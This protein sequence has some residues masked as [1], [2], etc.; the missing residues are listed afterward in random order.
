MT[1]HKW[2]V[3]AL[4]NADLLTAPV[5]TSYGGKASENLLIVVLGKT[6][7]SSG[8]E[9][10]AGRASRQSAKLSEC[11]ASVALPV[12][13]SGQHCSPVYARVDDKRNGE[14][15]PTLA[16]CC[17]QCPFGSSNQTHFLLIAFARLFA[18]FGLCQLCFGIPSRI[19]TII[20]KRYLSNSWACS[21]VRTMSPSNK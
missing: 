1:D 10:K 8:G 15:G 6:L 21:F 17:C 2:V 13:N 14:L 7:P 9:L 12:S 4:T 16:E 5:D 19:N 3:T 11:Q 20:P 18:S